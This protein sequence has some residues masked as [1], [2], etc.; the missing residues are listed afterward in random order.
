MVVRAL[1]FSQSH[2]GYMAFN[3]GQRILQKKRSHF[4]AHLQ[5]GRSHSEVITNWLLDKLDSEFFS[6]CFFLNSVCLHS[7]PSGGRLQ[8]K[9]VPSF[10]PPEEGFIHYFF[11]FC[12]KREVLNKKR[13]DG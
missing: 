5:S 2:L 12:E 8:I 10:G 1:G 3:R 13:E 9:A 7:G 6:Y 11:I 4:F